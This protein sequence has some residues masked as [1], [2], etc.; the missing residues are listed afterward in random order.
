MESKTLILGIDPGLKGALALYDPL[1]QEIVDFTDMPTTARPNGKTEIDAAKLL[2]WLGGKSAGRDASGDQPRHS[3]IRYC[4]LERVHAQT[5][6]DGSGQRRGQGAVASFSFGLGYGIVIG[7]LTALGI[8]IYPV[9]PAVWKGALG[10]SSD[11]MASIA[12]ARKRWPE[13]QDSL[14]RK[15]DDGR[16]E[17]MLIAAFGE[18]LL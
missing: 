15:K 9:Q 11:K 7:V 6:I 12:L 18:R 8:P 10:L 3:Q 17:A 1:F 4:L 5:Y 2:G 14:T 13:L 16:A